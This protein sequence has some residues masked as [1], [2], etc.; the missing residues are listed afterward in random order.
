VAVAAL[1][2]GGERGEALFM[3]L[4]LH[5]LEESFDVVAPRAE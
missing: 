2:V 1:A 3:S 4:D 5:T